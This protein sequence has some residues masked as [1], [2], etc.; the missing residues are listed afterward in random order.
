[1]VPCSCATS[2]AGVRR[3][4]HIGGVRIVAAVESFRGSIGLRGHAELTVELEHT[5]A[6]ASGGDLPAVL[7]TPRLLQL[8]EDA[9][10]SLASR[11]L[12]DGYT[13]VGFEF[14]IEHI[15]PSQVGD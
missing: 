9:C 7:S 11:Y 15:A 6:H 3:R 10:Y 12:Q 2:C 14:V 8:V 4:E 1:M 13:S 5:A